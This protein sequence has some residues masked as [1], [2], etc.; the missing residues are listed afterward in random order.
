MRALNGI[1]INA[2]DVY[3]DESGYYNVVAQLVSEPAYDELR[4]RFKSMEA[5]AGRRPDSKSTGVIPLDIDIVIFNGEV[6]RPHDFRQNYFQQCYKGLSIH[7]KH[8]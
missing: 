2:S 6:V 4:C 8:N 1:I 5:E 3:H 7:E